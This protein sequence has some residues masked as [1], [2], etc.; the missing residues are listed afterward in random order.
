MAIA[1]MQDFP[2][3]TQE[4]YDQINDQVLAQLDLGGHT[5]KGCLFHT[6]GPIEG[7]WRVLDVWES[8]DALNTFLGVLGPIGQSAGIAQ[9]QVTIWPL[10]NILTP[11]GY[12]LG[13]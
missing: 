3:G 9:P 1:V 10:H 13:G 7:G 4:Q 8:Q 6:A 11:K 2:G 12:A 5:P